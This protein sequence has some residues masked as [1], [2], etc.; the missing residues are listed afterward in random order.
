M[1][2]QTSIDGVIS[3]FASA[4]KGV[5]HRCQLLDAGVTPAQIKW[6]L[7]NG[8]LFEIHRG[9]Y[10]VGHTEMP[11]LA[12]EIA[13][14][15]ACGA[16]AVVRH[17]SAGA[18]WKICSIA[19]YAP[20]RIAIP[21]ARRVKRPGIHVVRTDLRLSEWTVREGIRW[22]TPIRTVLDLAVTE[23]TGEL[24][25]IVSQAEYRR[26]LNGASVQEYLKR[27]PGHPGASNLCDVMD[28]EGGAQ[29][30][31][32]KGERQLLR[33][34]REGGFSGYILNSDIFGPELDVVWPHL[35]LAIELDGRAGHDG[36]VA[37][38]RDRRKIRSQAVNGVVIVPVTGRMLSRE[39]DELERDL[40]AILDQRK[41]DLMEG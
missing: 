2:P 23:D 16:G 15:F 6:R 20:A 27:N 9:V 36:T 35:R 38:E 3:S 22:T 37:F 13:A 29:R 32:S 4:Q 12:K 25:Y 40:H 7:A 21:A 11:P 5:V 39:P 18:F 10:L 26:R 30:T 28:I 17:R 19:D 31:R 33:L 34:L 8:R 1:S 41:R 24:E 14:M